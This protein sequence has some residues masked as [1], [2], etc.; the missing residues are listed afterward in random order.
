MRF[1][2][3]HLPQVSA[4]LVNCLSADGL[5]VGRQERDEMQRS[6][7]FEYSFGKSEAPFWL[8]AVGMLLVARIAYFARR[9]GTRVSK[10]YPETL[11]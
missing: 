8:A 5:A 1:E 6:I 9:S 2:N 3:R 11:A 7:R 4:Y 10:R